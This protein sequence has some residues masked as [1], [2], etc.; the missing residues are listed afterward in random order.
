[1]TCGVVSYLM[2]DVGAGGGAGVTSNVRLRCGVQPHL[3]SLEAGDG[4]RLGER[5]WSLSFYIRC[6][7]DG[8]ILYDCQKRYSPKSR[9]WLDATFHQALSSTPTVVL[10]FCHAFWV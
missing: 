5:D 4:G 6:Q 7:R 1:M 8:P 2:I 3:L 10:L 9:E